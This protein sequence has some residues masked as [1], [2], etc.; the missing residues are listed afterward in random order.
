MLVWGFAGWEAVT[1]LSPDYRD[2]ARDMPARR[3]SR[4]SWSGVLYLGVALATVAVLGPALASQAPLADL[5]AVGF[6]GPVRVVTAVVAVLLTLGAMNAYFAGAAR[7]GAAL[8]RDGALPAW[9][10]RGSTAGEV[11]RRSLAVVTAGSLLTLLG[12]ALT[13]VAIER[14]MLLVDRLLRAGLRARH[15]GRA[16]AAAAR[17]VGPAWREV[18]FASCSAA[19]R[20]DGRAL[21]A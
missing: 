21:L 10:A 7:L 11:P 5:L 8:G 3:R 4:W 9:F 14:T 6:G 15:R 2:P 13:G 19:A 12:V 1:S 18:A 20:A 16:A 17:H